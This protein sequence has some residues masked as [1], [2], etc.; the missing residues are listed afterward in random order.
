MTP[1]EQKLWERLRNDQLG[2]YHFR[3]QQMID[4]FIVDFYCNP[5]KLVIEVNGN[6]HKLQREYD[7]VREMVL[8][9]EEIK[10]LRVANE[11]IDNDMEVVL[12]DILLCCKRSKIRNKSQD[13]Y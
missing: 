3:R 5:L 12:Q 9:S 6:I 4:G 1:Q 8:K 10:I 2:G 13:A 7:A 11:E